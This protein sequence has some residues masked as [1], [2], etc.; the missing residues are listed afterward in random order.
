MAELWD[1]YDRKRNKTGATLE[2][3]TPM[4]ADQYHLI[5]QVWIQN[6]RGQ[7]LISRRAPEKPLALKWEAPGGSVLAGE[8]SKTG[9]LR[10]V[11]EELG[12]AL[13]PDKGCLF[14]TVRRDQPDWPLP[15]FLDVWV[16]QHDSDIDEITLQPGETVDARWVNT[17]ELKALIA[18]GAFIPIQQRSYIL[19]LLDQLG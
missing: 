13:D 10:E 19:D 5:V 17:D 6:S 4:T 8:D 7:W 12:V 15:S 11:L 1:I 16:F 14:T 2:R 9:A 18:A 3:G